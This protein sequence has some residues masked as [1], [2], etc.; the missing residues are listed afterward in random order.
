MID[1]PGRT[2]PPLQLRDPRWDEAP[3]HRVHAVRRHRRRHV[4]LSRLLVLA[5]LA[6]VGYVA[7]KK[8][9]ATWAQ[10]WAAQRLDRTADEA[11]APALRPGDPVARLTVPSLALDVMALEGVDEATL[12][13]G[14]GHFPGSALPGEPGNASFAG[15][16]DTFFRALGRV[17]Q[18]TEIH[19][20]TSRGA[21]VYQVTETRVVGPDAVEVVASLPGSHLTLVTCYPFDWVGPAPRRFV[22]RAVLLGSSSPAARPVPADPSA[23]RALR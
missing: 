8:L 14:A 22:V 15:H 17:E 13:R 18:G 1:E 9:E 11:E 12:D 21:H 19:L 10:R 2:D 3:L 16:R 6:L 5:G 7:A 23:A 4:W 20:E